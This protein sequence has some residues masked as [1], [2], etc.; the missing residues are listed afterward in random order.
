MNSFDKI[1][2]N[3]NKLQTLPTI[4]SSISEA[5]KDPLVT[6]EKLARIIT[7]DQVSSF[8]ILKVANSPFY[9]F[10]GR[11]D[12]ISQAILYLGFDEIK[13]IIFALSVVNIFTKDKVILNFKPTD[14]WAHSI[15][16]GI[17][18]RLIGSAIGEKELENYF[19]A[20]IIH[21]IGKLLFI[22][23][24]PNDFEK[25]LKLV[26]QKD[27]TIR[28]AETEILG[29][30]HCRAGQILAEKWKL[31]T[32]L[33]DA[34]LY[35]HNGIKENQTNRLIASVHIADILATAL[36]LGRSGDLLIPEPNF[37]VWD[38]IKLPKGFF[39]SIKKKL[40]EDFDQ[41]V[42]VMLYQ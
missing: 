28:E 33:Q 6:P 26:V 9:G 18:T 34:I 19:L 32:G 1:L 2:Q 22:E 20:G 29:I 27:C 36:E 35:H 10:R 41:T 42:R 5:L 16:V 8:K 4:Y 25:V 38:I 30:D 23:F 13:N 37:K 15:A 14:L 3:V 12:T 21:D 31:P 39:P 24:L 17:T 11:I 40:I 7:V